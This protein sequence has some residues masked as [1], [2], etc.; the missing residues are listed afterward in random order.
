MSLQS[1]FF[2][3]LLNSKRHGALLALAAVALG[4]SSFALLVIQGTM[5]GLQS[6]VESRSKYYK[7]HASLVFPMTDESQVL[8]VVN[9]LRSQGMQAIPMLELEVLVKNGTYTTAAKLWALHPEYPLPFYEVSSGN[10]LGADLGLVL[11]SH[12][13]SELEVIFPTST[14]PL[15]GDVPRTLAMEAGPSLMTQLPEVDATLLLTRASMVQ[16]ILRYRGMNQIKIFS[17]FDE[18]IIKQVLAKNVL[19]GAIFR[20][21]EQ[22]NHTLVWALGMES[23]VMIFLFSAMTALVSLAIVSG[24]MLY[25]S[26]IKRDLIALWVLGLGLRDIK[27]QMQTLSQILCLGPILIGMI[28]GLIFLLA[29]DHWGGDIMPVIFVERKIPIAF[30]MRYFFLSI[31]IPYVISSTAS[32]LALH[33]LGH[34]KENFLHGLRGQG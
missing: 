9:V 14:D 22:E 27:K 23:A 6:G 10:A 12:E 30:K 24:L 28:L 7:A 31:A 26:K 5:G 18:K 33:I 32:W 21:W 2:K 25:F 13:G 8:E 29:L 34:S 16:N 1:Y 11:K 19:P 15:L 20:T 17:T 3:I 4:L